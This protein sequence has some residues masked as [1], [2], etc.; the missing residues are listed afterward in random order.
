MSLTTTELRRWLSDRLCWWAFRLDPERF[1][2]QAGGLDLIHREGRAVCT[3]ASEGDLFVY[4]GDPDWLSC[5]DCDGRVRRHSPAATPE[6]E[7]GEQL[8]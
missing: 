2:D 4:R 3:C 6:Q 7:S 1:I 8:G 5:A